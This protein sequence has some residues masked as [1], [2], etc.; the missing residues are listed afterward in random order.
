MRQRRAGPALFRSFGAL[1]ALLAATA[2]AGC[3]GD[4]VLPPRAAGTPT[5]IPSATPFATLPTPTIITGAVVGGG[6]EQPYTVEPGDSLLAIAARFGTTVE[7]IQERNKLTGTEILVGQQLSVPRSVRLGSGAPPAA[8]TPAPPPRPGGAAPTATPTAGGQTYLVQ[9]GDTA[10]GIAFRFDITLEAL[11]A[12]NGMT[13]NQV[14]RLQAGQTL[15]IP[16]PR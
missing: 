9:P 2:V 8:A 1:A 5:P 15:Q 12:A 6:G 3:G 7:A 10:L 4:P 14:S 11:A 13:V 16:R